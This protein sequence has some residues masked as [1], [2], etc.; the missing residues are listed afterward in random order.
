MEEGGSV[1]DCRRRGGGNVGGI[2]EGREGKGVGGG[3]GGG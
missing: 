2:L 3:Q 1:V